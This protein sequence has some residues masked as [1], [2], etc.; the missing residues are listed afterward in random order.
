MA[1]GR[2]RRNARRGVAAAVLG[3]LCV[4][5]VSVVMAPGASAAPS[6]TVTIDDVTPPVV[7][8]DAGGSVRFVNAIRP[9]TAR[10]S[11][12]VVGGVSATVHRDVAVTFFGEKRSLAAGASTGWVFPQTTNGSITYTFRIVP[13]SGLAAAVADQVV[14]AVRATL[15]NGGAPVTVPYVVQTI[16]PD[17]PNPPSVNVPEL[18][19]VEVPD[20]TGEQP[21]VDVPN[22]DEGAPTEGGPTEGGPDGTASPG[23]RPEAIDGDQYTYGQGGGAPQMA[24]VDSVAARAFDPDRFAP[25]GGSADSAARSGGPGGGGVAGAYDGAAVPVFGQLAGIDGAS[26]DDEAAGE[27]LATSGAGAQA[28]P[29]AALAAVVALATATAA[30]VRTHQAHRTTRR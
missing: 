3:W 11:I 21:P 7:S 23:S 1:T 20:P 17:L 16:V 9:D 15:D 13:Q 25:S 2:I 5:A 18:P 14:S 10:V 28:L 22:D 4:A 6:A 30:L 24:A 27:E 29:A 12:P 8:V 19:A 26:L